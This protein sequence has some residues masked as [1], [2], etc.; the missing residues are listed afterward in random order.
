MSVWVIAIAHVT[1]VG[2]IIRY[3]FWPVMLESLKKLFDA[4]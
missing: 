4:F 2:A 3:T 1:V